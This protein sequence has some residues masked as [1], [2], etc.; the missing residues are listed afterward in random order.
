M[1]FRSETFGVKDSKGTYYLDLSA[2]YPIADTGFT[3]IAHWGYQ[4]YKGTSTLNPTAGGVTQSNDSLFSYKDVKLGL[5]YALPKDFTVG[6][7][8]TKAYNYNKAGYGGGTDGSASSNLWSKGGPLEKFD[9]LLKARG[10]TE[11]ARNFELK[12]ALNWLVNKETGHYI[13]NSSLAEKDAEKAAALTWWDT[14]LMAILEKKSARVR[15]FA[16]G[17]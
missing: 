8:Y 4:K 3:L 13:P 9:S 5:S 14:K 11:G 10:Q 12:P 17:A 16:K 15:P 7:Y 2:N 6:A 1:L